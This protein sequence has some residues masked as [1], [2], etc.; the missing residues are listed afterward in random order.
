MSIAADTVRYARYNLTE[1]LRVPISWIGSIVFP[2]LSFCFFVLPQ[3]SIT[4][5]R[6]YATAA[7]VQLAVFAIMTNALFGFG[8]GIAQ[9][10]ERP[11]GAFLRT[12]PTP[13]VARILGEVCSTGL[14]GLVAVVPLV[15]LGGAFTSAAASPAR[16]G[17]GL[18]ALALTGL[19]SMFLG[20]CIG[21][22][23]GSKAAIAVVQTLMF[24][25][26]F[27]GGL[28]LPPEAFPKWLDALSLWLPARQARD[29]CIW[30][31]QGGA[32]NGWMIPG[33]AAW[34]V[35]LLAGALLLLRRDASRRFG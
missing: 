7:V 31:V 15:A 10:R 27:G 18:I 33:L 16:I 29:I 22:A 35:A 34:T 9:S 2:S 26:A 14:V 4:G 5:D 11:W 17:L 6:T 24:A 12:L 32:L 8:L 13:G 30:A 28:F 1:T 23:L 3:S 20:C 19:P 25:L 21:Y